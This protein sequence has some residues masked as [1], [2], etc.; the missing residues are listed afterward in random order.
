MWQTHKSELYQAMIHVLAL[1]ST[2]VA[3]VDM[4]KYGKILLGNKK[5]FVPGELLQCRVT[6]LHALASS[7][8]SQ[9]DFGK[10]HLMLC[11]FMCKWGNHI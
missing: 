11:V 5:L 1:N 10:T 2:K 8:L 6:L 4:S 9:I 7:W 3:G